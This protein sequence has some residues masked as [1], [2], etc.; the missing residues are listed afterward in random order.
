MCRLAP[1][2]PPWLHATHPEVLFSLFFLLSPSTFHEA[3]QDVV[4]RPVDR[5]LCVLCSF[6]PPSPAA[7]FSTC[8]PPC[9]QSARF[10]TATTAIA[11]TGAE[12][13]ATVS[14]GASASPPSSSRRSASRSSA[15]SSS[16]PS[17]GSASSALAS[18]PSREGNSLR[19]A[20][21]ELS[22]SSTRRYT[23]SIAGI[24]TRAIPTTRPTRTRTLPSASIRTTTA[25]STI[26]TTAEDAIGSTSD[27]TEARRRRQA[28]RIRNLKQDQRRQEGGTRAVEGE[29][30][31]DLAKKTDVLLDLAFA[32]SA[33]DPPRLREPISMPAFQAIPYVRATQSKQSRKS[34]RRSCERGSTEARTGS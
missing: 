4:L 1:S 27:I 30:E 2:H 32:S 22:R 26:A 21:S 18:T 6:L 12:G 7:A 29:F 34:E 15:S 3:E 20:P 28:R 8:A 24:R 19:K 33:K 5:L 16:S 10:R 25:L 23:T 31:R 13:A 17:G 11:G 9:E 14:R